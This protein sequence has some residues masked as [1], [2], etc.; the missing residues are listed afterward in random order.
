[1]S[2]TYATKLLRAELAKLQQGPQGGPVP[3]LVSQLH[4]AITHLESRASR[5]AFRQNV[6]KMLQTL[7]GV[8]SFLAL[9]KADPILLDRIAEACNVDLH[10]EAQGSLSDE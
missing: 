8:D 9:R 3:S 7:G 5:E 10:L 2:D 1:M 6:S 4:D